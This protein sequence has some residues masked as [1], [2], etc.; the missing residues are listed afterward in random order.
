MKYL[1]KKKNVLILPLKK[2]ISHKMSCH[3][4][5]VDTLLNSGVTLNL[6]DVTA[7]RKQNNFKF[8]INN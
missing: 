5:R 8:G 3:S 7:K 4:D 6:F 1:K 2:L